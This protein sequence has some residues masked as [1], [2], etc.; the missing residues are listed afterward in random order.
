MADAETAMAFE[1]EVLNE[2]LVIQ[3]RYDDLSIP[4]DLR[5]EVHT[6]AGRSTVELRRVLDDL[7]AT[8]A[9]AAAESPEG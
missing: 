2:D 7:I 3:S 5:T 9:A 4:L 8:V 6:R 1:Q